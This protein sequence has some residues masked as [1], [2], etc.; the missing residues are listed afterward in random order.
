MGSRPDLQPL[1]DRLVSGPARVAPAATACLVWP[2]GTWVGSAGVAVVE[3]GEA[4]R[5]EARMRIQSNSKTWLIAVILQLINDGRM[6]LEDTVGQ[7]L[8]DLLPYG[9][10][11]TVRGLITDTSGLIDD[12]DMMNS[13]TGTE[14]ALAN[15]KDADL[16][17]QLCEIFAQVSDNRATPVDPMWLIRMAS[18]QP[19]VLAPGTGY[20][21]SNI[22]WNIAGLVTER[23]AGVPLATLY[24]QRIFAPLGLRHT[25]YQPQGP[26]DGPHAEGYLIEDDGSLTKS[27]AWTAGKGADGAIVTNAAEEA[28]FLRALVND[29]LGVRQPFLAFRAAPGSNSGGCP[30]NAFVGRG[31]GAASRS[32]VY[33]D[34]TGA[35]VAVLLVN[36]FRS[37]SGDS[38]DTKAES[39]ALELY[40]AA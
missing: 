28:I 37:G 14:H 1:L 8:P 4:I 26:T 7:W 10:E 21:H 40:C 34:Q 35:R 32:Y 9:D 11:I 3:T 38:G 24:E 15:V 30:G 17:Q 23:A 2:E 6:T 31:A 36:G 19:L 39:A 25:S 22:G 12:N 33:Y 5:P 27:T 13:L 16:R 20:H 29:D 18:W